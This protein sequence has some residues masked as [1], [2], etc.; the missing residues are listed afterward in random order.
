M[1]K[2]VKMAR[3]DHWIKQLF[4]LP[5]VVSALA[6][7][8]A[9]WDIDLIFSVLLGLGSTCLVASSNYMINE[10]LDAE[11]DKYHPVKKYRP[12]VT[13]GVNS[14]IVYTC[15]FIL[16][17]L[18]IVLGFVV[19]I[20]FGVCAI[21]LWIMGVLYNVRPFRMKDV[22]YLDVLFES[23]N[24]AIRLLLGWFCCVDDVLPPSSLVV[25][26]WMAGA[27]LM[28]MKR[29]AEYNMINDPET[30]GLYRKSFRKYTKVS[31]L[32]SS[33]LYG[34]CS[35]FLIGVFL[36]KYRIELLLAVP[37]IAGLF[38]MYMRMA[39]RPDSVVQRPE[40]L[41][42]ERGLLLYLVFLCVLICVLLF[43]DIPGMERFVFSDLI[44]LDWR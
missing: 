39:F 22:P 33:F 42:R 18:G 23:V 29:F 44:L 37:F 6:F 5:G 15:Y 8:G 34:M 36:V 43:V 30:A 41:Y 16:G 13:E 28:A 32:C 12:A 25:G 26:Y 20:P 35:V 31:L 14:R 2:Y 10:W 21:W 9:I 24:N 7:A 40:K 3:P 1:N 4:I 38:V 27:F 19:S 11:F 17:I